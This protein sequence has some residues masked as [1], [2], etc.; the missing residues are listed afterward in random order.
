MALTMGDAGRDADGA[1][2]QTR[3]AGKSR[4]RLISKLEVVTVTPENAPNDDLHQRAEDAPKRR[5]YEVGLS[6]TGL[7]AFE[8][9][10]IGRVM[11]YDRMYYH[12]KVRAAEAM[13]RK[14]VQLAEQEGSR[15]LTLAELFHEVS[16]ETM[17]DLLGGHV[18]S[19]GVLSGGEH[20]AGVRRH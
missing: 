8:Q 11:L 1:C 14:L 10:I 13:A 15:N 9:M 5:F 17:I 19:A 12:H 20:A 4:D 2:P 7:G 16:D 6:L 18:R 3:A